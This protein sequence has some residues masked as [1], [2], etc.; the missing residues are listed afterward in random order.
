MKKIVLLLF[1]CCSIAASFAQGSL[2]QKLDSL[3]DDPLFETTQVGLMVYD[4]T[5]D[6]T[7]YQYHARHLMRPAST[8]KVITAITALDRLGG[9]YMFTTRFC[10]TG[11]IRNGKLTGNLYCVGGFDPMVTVNDVKTMVARLYELGVDTLRGHIYADRSMKEPVDWGEGW[12]WDDENP[13]LTPLSI[14]RQDVFTDC[15][16][17]ELQNIGIVLQNV[18]VGEAVCPANARLIGP[19]FHTIDQVMDRMMKKSDNFHAEAMFYQ[20]AASTGKPLSKATHASSI[21]RQLIRRIG[22]NANS[23]RIADG[24]GLSLYNYVSAELETMMLRY[25]WRNSNIYDHLAP[26]LPIAGVDGTLEK[27]MRGTAAQGNVRAKTGT[28]TGISSLAGYCTAANGHQLCFSI[29]NQG[30]MR[31]ADG[32]AFQDRVCVALCEP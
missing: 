6:Q 32:K 7:V 29:I 19:C 24:S 13:R 23:Y 28:L 31:G 27:R 20:I 14:G 25:A 9:D 10:Y 18:T 30:V 12:C 1:F 8:M 2:R 3:L 15:V 26:S 17:R 22:L 11:S 21:V 4:L 5:A 16:V